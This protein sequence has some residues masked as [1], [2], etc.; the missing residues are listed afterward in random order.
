MQWKLF[1]IIPLGKG[2]G[3]SFENSPHQNNKIFLAY[4]CT[5]QFLL[6]IYC[7]KCSPV[8]FPIIFY[9]LLC[10]LEIAVNISMKEFLY[11]EL[12]F[13]LKNCHTYGILNAQWLIWYSYQCSHLSSFLQTHSLPSQLISKNIQLVS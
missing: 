8:N 12:Y 1:V 7:L 13:T 11:I 9:F 10:S 2:R 5:V 6:M 3:S 4:V